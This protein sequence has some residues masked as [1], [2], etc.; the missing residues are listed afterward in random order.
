[1][2]VRNVS[3]WRDLK[4]DWYGPYGQCE[5]CWY[6]N[7]SGIAYILGMVFGQDIKMFMSN[8]LSGEWMTGALIVENAALCGWRSPT[9]VTINLLCS[10]VMKKEYLLRVYILLTPHS[11]I[12]CKK[13]KRL[14]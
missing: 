4:C 6:S 11:S 14:P 9:L 1:M 12:L 8:I 13:K 10:G 3:N 2:T 7:A 5:V